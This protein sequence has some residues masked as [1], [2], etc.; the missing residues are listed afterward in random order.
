MLEVSTVRIFSFLMILVVAFLLLLIFY[1][2]EK[3]KGL[4][5]RRFWLLGKELDEQRPKKISKDKE[6]T[7]L[8]VTDSK[9]KVYISNEAKHVFVCG[10]TGSGKTVAL[11]NFIESAFSY[12]YPMLLLDGKGDTGKGSILDITRTLAGD[13]KV[14]VID[15]N[16]PEASDK[17]NPF[18]NT[19]ADIIKDML[20]N[21]TNW[22][23]EHYKY[24]T[25]V[26]IQALCNLLEHSGIKIS[27]DSIMEN[28]NYDNFV[29]LSKSVSEQGL[30]PK[31]EHFKN[32]DLAKTGSQIASGASARFNVIKQ[33]RLGQIFHEDGIDVHTAMQENACIV[34]I[35]SPLIYPELSPLIGRLVIIDAKKAVN[36]LYEN[37]KNRV[38]YI[39]DEI[40]VYA[41][42]NMLDLVNK[43]RS[44][45][46]TCVLAAQSLSDLEAVSGEAFR[47]QI[48]ENCNN[49]ILLRQNSP[50]NAE[51]WAKVFG[52]RQ[53]MK[54]TSKIADD[55]MTSEGSV[56]QVHEYLYHPDN[57]KRLAVG[58]AIFMSRD[59]DFHT[60]I[61]V[62]KPF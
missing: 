55:E 21:M 25:E 13:K 43:S 37:K 61:N 1:F 62:N 39:M 46:V 54:Y 15:L 38:F 7:F 8:G 32:L 56:R 30:I 53:A 26:Y 34:F 44:A 35:L 24:N 4:P 2:L 52:T 33:S 17:Y 5:H 23:E 36:G 41:S 31:E 18:N 49:Y 50:K 57:I 42:N 20:I 22:S 48:I 27:F 60:K 59:E 3:G 58:K 11:S 12:D 6:R 10:T 29:L 16:N 14:Y 40:N 47:E 9:K 28:L 51:N 45:N 19:N